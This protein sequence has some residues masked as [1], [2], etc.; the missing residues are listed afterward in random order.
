MQRFCPIAEPSG[1]VPPR[2]GTGSRQCLCWTPS[3]TIS[4]RYHPTLRSRKA[5]ARCRFK[6]KNGRFWRYQF[7]TEVARPKRFELVNADQLGP[8]H[9][10]EPHCVNK[11]E[12][13]SG[14]LLRPR[15]LKRGKSQSV[16]SLCAPELLIHLAHFP[17][18][19]R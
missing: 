17:G 7:C 18:M 11:R 13:G 12:Q 19:L 3:S 4:T 15:S 10:G 6:R 9:R 1:R 14:S 16:D 8:D 2:G 5:H